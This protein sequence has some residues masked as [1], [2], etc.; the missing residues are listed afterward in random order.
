M[1]GGAGGRATRKL[2]LYV[3]HSGILAEKGEEFEFATT[4]KFWR[5]PNKNLEN[6]TLA[7]K[8]F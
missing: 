3:K 6:A 1:Q 2:C 7:E 8:R 4:A 5:F